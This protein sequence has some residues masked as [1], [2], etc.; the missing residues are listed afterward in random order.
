MLAKF[1]ARKKKAR[2]KPKLK[3]NDPLQFCDFCSKM[4]KD[5]TPDFGAMPDTTENLWS[6]VER[7]EKEGGPASALVFLF[8]YALFY[9]GIAAAAA[10]A[11]SLTF[12]SGYWM[13]LLSLFLIK[14][15]LV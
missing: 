9:F 1:P 14:L 6:T 7:I 15:L 12:G 4:D 10:W 3:L 5:C 13:T 8:I 11:V 2:K